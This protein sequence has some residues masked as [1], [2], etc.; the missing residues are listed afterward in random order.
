MSKGSSEIRNSA[1][2][3][4]IAGTESIFPSRLES[5][6]SSSATRQFKLPERLCG[7]PSKKV[8]IGI[9]IGAG[10]LVVGGIAAGIAKTV[11]EA[12]ATADSIEATRRA[13]EETIKGIK[14]IS[15]SHDA[16]NNSLPTTATNPNLPTTADTEAQKNAISA[17]IDQI[18]QQNQATSEIIKQ[19][20]QMGDHGAPVVNNKRALS[21]NFAPPISSDAAASVNQ[22]KVYI[23]DK[24]GVLTRS[25]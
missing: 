14:Q 25:A 19:I 2:N 17:T 1:S 24:N 9:G 10:V 20:G 16:I 7:L 12:K 23:P 15:N 21:D 3:V 4:R 8:L 22:N 18:N 13:T 11:I 6:G 5:Q